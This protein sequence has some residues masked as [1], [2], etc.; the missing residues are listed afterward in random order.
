MVTRSAAL[1]ILLLCTAALAAPG[2]TNGPRI[3]GIAHIAYYVTSADRARAYYENFLGFEEAFALKNQDGSDHIVCVKIND[4]QYIELR[5]EPPVN[6]G[7]LHDIAFWTTDAGAVRGSLASRESTLSPMNPVNNDEAGDLGF[8]ITDPFGFK[9]RIVQYLADS[10]TG[11]AKGARMPAT[12]L[13]DHIDHVGIL[14]G[15]RTVAAKFYE[16]AFGFVSEGDGSKQRIGTGPDRFEL[17]FERKPPTVD[18]FHVKNHICLSVADVPKVA[19]MLQ[20]KPAA[21]EFRAIETHVLDNGKHV[22]ELYDADGNRVE[23]ME[24][25]RGVQ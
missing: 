14:I 20:G 6:H 9:V 1:S 4:R 17:G 12:R 18:R 23:L 3:E 16:D 7:F 13:S 8:D 11:A 25:P 19:A 24:P 22:A 21:K 2:P 5:V 15:D 10:R